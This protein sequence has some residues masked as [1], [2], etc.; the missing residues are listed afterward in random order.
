[1]TNPLTHSPCP[2]CGSPRRWCRVSYIEGGTY[3]ELSEEPEYPGVPVP[4][5]GFAN[6]GGMTPHS[7]DASP[8]FLRCASPDCARVDVAEGD[9][10]ALET[11]IPGAA[12]YED[13]EHPKWV[14]LWSE[15][16]AR[17]VLSQGDWTLYTATVDFA[18]AEEA[19]ESWN[20]DLYAQFESHGFA[21]EILV[22]G[23]VIFRSGAAE[24]IR[25][26]LHVV[27]AA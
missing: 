27:R 21:C 13:G 2:T 7:E 26:D 1:M 8:F 3:L 6:W 22:D 24:D 16:N 11:F 4:N 18:S 5:Q 10:Q 25:K 12:A 19:V 9:Q 17:G 14:A 23:E 15:P 20:D